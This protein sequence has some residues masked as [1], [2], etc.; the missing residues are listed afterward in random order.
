VKR[1][2]GKGYRANEGRGAGV[3]GCRGANSYNVGRA[4][5]TDKKQNAKKLGGH[6]RKTKSRAIKYRF[7]R[8]GVVA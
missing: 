4:G 1:S 5:A 3:Q 7:C 6:H 8:W 2:R